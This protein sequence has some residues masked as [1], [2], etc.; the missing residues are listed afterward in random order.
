MLSVF[1]KIK[2]SFRVYFGL[3]PKCNSDAPEK[4]NCKICNNF[5]GRPNKQ[6]KKDWL[7]NYL[8]K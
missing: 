7:K 6:Q 4:D 1:K 3:C 8:D 2:S 5:Y